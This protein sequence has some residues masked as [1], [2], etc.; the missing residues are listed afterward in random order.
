MIRLSRRP[1]VR[2]TAMA[3]IL[4]GTGLVLSGAASAAGRQVVRASL[5][6]TCRA[7]AGW[8]PIPAQVTVGIPGT[9]TA[10]QAIR[11]TAP[12]I[13]VT[14]PRADGE[15]LAKLNASKVSL[16]PQVR[17]EAAANGTPMAD[18]WLLKTVSAPVPA[19][20]DLVLQVPGAVQPVAARA[21]G[22]VTFT[23][24]DLSLLLA[25]Q[26][27]H[28]ST[29][30]QAPSATA[31]PAPSA[32]AS[33]APSATTS[34]ATSPTTSPAPMRLSCTLNPGQTA[35]LATVP[36]VATAGPAAAPPQTPNG[37]FLTGLWQS[38]PGGSFSGKTGKTKQVTLKDAA[39]GAVIACAS[40]II[41]GT[42][43]FGQQLPP[44]G[45]A[46]FSS[47]TLLTCTG[48]GG[49]TFTVT[50]SASA[51]HPWLLN[52]QSF[53]PT[54]SVPTV[55]I[56]G[57]MATIGASGCSATV[58]GPSPT[59]PGTVEGTNPVVV[60]ILGNPANNLSLSPTGGNLHIWNVKGC[61][62]LFSSGDV[63]TFTALYTST[64]LAQYVAQAECPPFP[65]NTG[66]PFNPH[67][68]LPGFPHK[69]AFVNNPLPAQGCAFIKG[70]TNVPKLN[71]AALVGPGF[72][73]IQNGKRTISNPSHN[74]Y[75]QL[76]STGKLY[77]KPCS[78]NAPKCK[79]IDGLP[80]VTA[81]LLGFGFV[82]TTATLQITQAGTLNIVSLGNTAG[83]TSSEVQ[84][85]ASIRVEKVLVNGAPLNVGNNCRTVRPFPLVLSAGSGYS[86][87]S[88]GVLNGTITV[89]PFT[90]CG[91]GENLDPIF[92]ATVSGPGNF[93]QLTQGNLCINWNTTGNSPG[94]AE[95][96]PASAPK[97][98]R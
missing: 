75:I 28:E 16:T 63:L 62:G 79:A 14:L 18:P 29:A 41:S 88:G 5:E 97:P 94:A 3:A 39:T 40:S 90:G 9:A 86:L 96:C 77:Y 61:S 23:A 27:T 53:D 31:I 21:A 17:G 73:N 58:A 30:T 92:N 66:F 65:V 71:G 52:G 72:G 57:I 84:S 81:T 35:T 37:H 68:K 76:D 60:P 78:G 4:A 50:T 26:I 38:A 89:P 44:A 19:H 87:D 11:P 56:S 47:V 98:I 12:A 22:N 74:G 93:V 95:G 83:L 45:L 55:T 15:H 43:K 33:P 64:T 70:F 80:P 32:T 69:G 36:V 8:Q 82:P 48:P 91:V 34:P 51:S 49:K 7:P 59:V 1:G 42:F 85:L 10:G 24:A 20:D 13:T 2:V 67:F 25:P 6:Y 46:S 54:T